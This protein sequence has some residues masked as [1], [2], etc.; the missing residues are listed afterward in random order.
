LNDVQQ[1]NAR[2]G[3]WGRRLMSIVSDASLVVL[4]VIR[5]PLTDLSILNKIVG[6]WPLPAWAQALTTVHGV[7]S[8]A[9]IHLSMLIV[10][11]VILVNR[12]DTRKLNVDWPFLIL[13]LWGALAFCRDYLWPVGWL[14]VLLAIYI[15]FT[16][17]KDGNRFVKIEQGVVEAIVVILIAFF[18]C[19][20][21][22]RTALDFRTIRT[23]VYWFLIGF[24]PAA[25]IEEVTFRGLL[26]MWLR[27]RNW[28]EVRIVVV[29]A[30][31]FWL[32]HTKYLLAE[33]VAFWVVVPLLSMLLGIIVWRTRSI[34]PSAI[35][36]ICINVCWSIIV[37]SPI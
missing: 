31:L 36:H 9:Y 6:Q 13:F 17:N 15:L 16:P 19:L 20:L 27:S 8:Y 11:I 32:A 21:F 2:H 22:L 23:A 10:A 1:V 26:W 30:I 25:M 33:P 37:N 29:Q 4:L 12:R 24:P 3:E 14:T 35:A 34:T 18:I 7:L 28:P 5:V